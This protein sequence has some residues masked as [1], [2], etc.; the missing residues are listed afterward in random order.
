MALVAGLGVTAIPASAQDDGWIDVNFNDWHV[1]GGPSNWVVEA[2][3]GL[4]RQLTNGEFTT[5]VSDVDNLVDVEMRGQVRVDTGSDNDLIGLVA[6]HRRPVAA[7]DDPW[8]ETETVI[9]GWK[10]QA[11]GGAPEGMKLSSIN[12]TVITTTPNSFDNT[13]FSDPPRAGTTELDRDTG[14]GTGWRASTWY[15]V[16]MVYRHDLVE[17]YVDDVLRLSAEGTFLPGRIGVYDQSQAS[18]AYRDF[19]YRHLTSPPT[20]DAGDDVSFDLARSATLDGS[21]STDPDGDVLSYDWAIV[22]EVGGPFALSDAQTANPVVTAEGPGTATIELT[23]SDG[24]ATDTDTVEVTATGSLQPNADAG[25]DQEVDEGSTVTLDSTASRAGITTDLAPSDAGLS[26]PG[27]TSLQVDLAGLDPDETGLV[28]AGRAGIGEGPPVEATTLVYVLDVSGSTGGGGGCGGNPNGHGGSNTIL[29]CEI[30]AL[31]ALHADVLSAGTVDRVGLVSFSSG[32]S[33]VDLDPTGSVAYLVPPDADVDGDGILDV[34]EGARRLRDGGGTNTTSGVVRACDL[35]A[36]ADT[37]NLVTVLM[38]D[39]EATTG[40]SFA[41][42]LPCDPPVT[43]QS[44]G[45]GSANSCSSGPSGRTL[46]ELADLTGGTCTHVATVEDLPDVLPDAI[47]SRITAVSYTIDGGD[48]VDLSGELGLPVTGPGG[49][50]LSIALPPGLAAGTHELCVSVTGTDA[51]GADTVTTCSSLTTISGELTHTWTQVDASGPP[52][53]LAGANTATPSFVAPD[54]GTYTFEVAVTDGAGRS[55]TDRVRVTVSN[56][57]PT[58][59]V[60]S[61]RSVAGGVTVV[62]G[63]FLD[64]GW[65]DTHTASIDWGD[66]TSTAAQVAPQGSGWGAVF[67]SHV[68]ADAGTYTVEVALVDDDG[69]TVAASLTE[70][71]VSEPVALWANSE[72]AGNALDWSGGAG[73]VHGLVHSNDDVNI[74]GRLKTFDTVEY[75]GSLKVGG[76]TQMPAETAVVEASQHPLDHELA[77]FAPDGPV[78]AAV[79]DAWHDDSGSCAGGTWHVVNEVLEPGVH[80]VDCDVQLNGSALGGAVTLVATGTISIAG[81]R[82]VFEPYWDGLLFL[83]GSSADRAIE[84]NSQGS[85]MLGTIFAPDGE[86]SLASSDNRF[87]C[88]VV[89]DRVTITGS[90]LALTG[91]DCSTPDDTSVG[92]LFVP[93]VTVDVDGTTGELVPGQELS[94]SVTVSHDG[95]QLVVPGLVGFENVDEVTAT[96]AGFDLLVERQSVATGGWEPIASSADGTVDLTLEANARPGTTFGPDGPLGT[97]VEPGAWATWGAQAVVALDAP[98]VEDLLDPDV[99]S[100]LR[101]RVVFGLQPEG[102]QARRLYTYGTDLLPAIR[103][104]GGDVTA[105]VVTLLSPIDGPVLLD[106]DDE[107]ALASLAPG[108]VVTIERTWSAPAPAPRSV[109]EDDAGYLARLLALDGSTLA[110]AA[111]AT[112][113]GAVGQLVAPVDLSTATVHL[114]IVTVDTAGPDRLIAG[115]AGDWDVDLAEVGT[116]GA[117]DVDV[118]VDADGEVLTLDPSVP[119]TLAVGE[120]F[121]STATWTSPTSPQSADVR[122]AVTWT[123]AAGTTYG[124]LGSNAPVNVRAPGALAVSLADALTTD[125][126]GDGRV[127]PGDTLTY[128]MAV[129]NSGGTALDDVV[130]TVPV[131]TGAT[132]VTGS[133]SVGTFADG[134]LTVPVGTLAAG[135]STTITFAV[136]VDDPF[137]TGLTGL[138]TVAT[139]SAPGVEDAVSDDPD[140]PGSANATTTAVVVPTPVLVAYLAGE[141]AIDADTSMTLSGGDTIRYDLEVASL[142]SQAVTGAVATVPIPAGTTLVA[143]SATTDT[144]TVSTTTDAVVVDLGDLAPEAR[145]A[146]AFKVTVDVPEAVQQVSAQATVTA[147]NH[148]DVASDDP[149]TFDPFGDATVLFVHGAPGGGGGGGTGGGGTGGGNPEEPPATIEPLS[150]ADGTT[151]TMPLDFATTLSAPDGETVSWVVTARRAGDAAAIELAAGDGPDVAATLDPTRLANGSWVVE[152]TA[153][154]SAGAISMVQAHVA[155]DGDFKPGRFVT[156]YLDLDV[157][158]AGLPV[159]VRRTYDSFD[160]STGDFGVGWSLDVADFEVSTNGPLGQGGWT[161]QGCGTGLVFVP[162]CFT[163]DTPHVVTVTW[164]DG[165]VEQFDLTPAKGSTFFPGLTTAQFTARPGATSKLAA[166]NNSLYF[167]NGDLLSGLFGIDGIYNPRQFRLTDQFGTEYLLGTRTGLVSMRDRLGDTVTIDED[168]ITSTSGTSVAFV[169]DAQGRITTVDG[170]GDQDVTYRYDTAGDLVEVVDHAGVSTGYRYEDHRLVE[171]LGDDEARLG[172]LEYVDGR[173]TRVLDAEGNPTEIASDVDGRAETVTTATGR[174]V[175]TLYDEDGNVERLVETGDERTYETLFEYERGLVT[176]RT[177]P[178]GR[179]WEASYDDSGRPEWIKD[180]TGAVRTFEFHP[181][182]GLLAA[183]EGPNPGQRVEYTYDA[184]GNLERFT[185]ATDRWITYGYDAR[186]R[187]T[188]MTDADGTTAWTYDAEGNL[189]TATDANNHTTKFETDHAGRPTVIT[190]PREGITRIA[191]DA[192]GAITSVETPTGGLTEWIYDPYRR[193]ER[194]VGP[195]DGEV[196]FTRD[197]AGRVTRVVDPEDRVTEYG[198][199]RAGR[200][201]SVTALDPDGPDAV[202]TMDY[203]EMGWLKSVTDPTGVTTSYE[204]DAAGRTVAVVDGAGRR[205]TTEWDA[206]DR[207]T[208]SEAP[209]GAFQSWTYDD[210]GFLVGTADNVGSTTYVN[211]D[212]GRV[213]EFLDQLDHLTRYGYDDV[214]RLETITDHRDGVVTYDYDAVGDVTSITDPIGVERTFT[215][216]DVGDLETATLPGAGTTTWVRD[217]SGRVETSTD[218]R[219][220]EVTYGWDDADRLTSVDVAGEHHGYDYDTTG[221]LTGMVDP[222]GTTTYQRDTRG[223]LTGVTDAAGTVAYGYDLAGRRTSLT[224]PTAL[225]QVITHDDAGAPDTIDVE[226][227]GVVD[228]GFDGDGR[229]ASLERPNGVDSTWTYDAAG[230]LD[231]VGH[232]LADGTTRAWDVTRDVAGNV[233][234]LDGPDGTSSYELDDLNRLVAAT[235]PDGDYAWTYD[236]ASNRTSQTVD[237]VITGSDIDPDTGL[238]TSVGGEAVTHDA[239]GNVTSVGDDT[240]TWDWAGRLASS[241]TDEGTGTYDYAGDGLRVEVDGQPQLLDRTTGSLLAAGGD[242]FAHG[243]AGPLAQEVGGEAGW[244]QADHLGSI[245]GVTDPS[246]ALAGTATF[247]PFGVQAATGT[248]SPFGF[249]GHLQDP[250]G[251]V[252]APLRSMDPGMGR[253]L[254]Q[255][256]VQPGAP[257]SAGYNLY[258]YVG[259]NPTSWTDPT[260]GVALVE[261]ASLIGRSALVGGILGGAFGLGIGAFACDSPSDWT[262]LA[263]WGFGGL[264]GGALGGAAW[265]LAAALGL[266][267]WAAGL[268]GGGVGGFTDSATRQGVAGGGVDWGAALLEGLI[269]AAAGGIL[270]AIIPALARR[271]GVSRS[272]STPSTGTGAADDF[273]R[274]PLW[275]RNDFGAHR[276]YQRTDLI[277]P[278]FVD[279]LGRTNLQRMQDGLAPIGPDGRSVNLHHML[280]TQDGP[281]AEITATM[282]QQYSRILHINPNT[283]PSGIDRAAF[284]RWRSDYWQWRAKDFL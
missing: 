97:T 174:V 94:T 275:S 64:Q 228:V 72:T 267:M 186:G 266:P 125:V 131:P 203:Y 4:V 163:S 220:I 167:S 143:G 70:L 116:R 49:V 237:G 229:L 235:T 210:A 169:R 197:G 145:A 77:D 150:V 115:D 109:D 19:Q 187:R 120:R 3:G 281:I 55:D 118:D 108:D 122:A 147:T 216:D 61:G 172:T 80:W 261:Y 12:G 89:G 165:R 98:A 277:D 46:Q 153:T 232:A 99:T 246:G 254:S 15:D 193:V 106:A 241:A 214:G 58:I 16:R 130:V 221:L 207:V 110:T 205:F 154:T 119:T 236:A 20:A 222:V 43:F 164:P 247:D 162:L 273:A 26:L 90:E 134:I 92:P 280:Q 7:G 17:V 144:G 251:L 27:G 223:R 34:V 211:D 41:S 141:L 5:M 28:A 173:L 142:G 259:S 22:A 6:G 124:P 76:Q 272:T 256:P 82:P 279:D 188:S 201:T 50:D 52:I 47:A 249:T 81:S 88:A 202:S 103:A 53:F 240:Y 65:L 56:V 180:A 148:A 25:D 40:S 100:G 102:V 51:G 175:T 135:A 59:E 101:T 200:V 269:G 177:D 257:G 156:T 196:R 168:G 60:D 86:V 73:T 133:A 117:L 161:M 264:V 224:S 204:Y 66:G 1:E 278:S 209:S 199:D 74:V 212:A 185:D 129:T 231:T 191:Y 93:D 10:E 29:D 155:V 181:R 244:L 206:L 258:G 183:I 112:G 270:D 71:G 245:T 262:C 158:V 111:F 13:W 151:V 23:V 253:W 260:G 157:G 45:V 2:G 127:S 139:A 57:D 230:R 159:Q 239:A 250:T 126:G 37:P 171:V 284:N 87:H 67:G 14:G 48:P 218:A 8:Q 35:L 33:Q 194:I 38:S 271:L 152:V 227:L 84:L 234:A 107:P 132:A 265:A 213:V 140:R 83:S 243:P 113:T 75:V 217:A 176:K 54:D 123:D 268:I 138:T 170:P 179:T 18:V 24:T 11:Q 39:G 215:Y 274:S 219:G 69:G 276:V 255:D 63:S 9:F 252:A 190:D 160:R 283:I 36:T 96:V 226:G 21:G 263:S 282:H 242:A 166:V 68:Y 146:I 62:S 137:P 31:E 198:H 42:V 32:S 233:T 208:R 104:A 195:D 225:D 238:L 184:D 91:A 192:V 114:P 30:A 44:F 79:G 178:L 136:L 85:K 149:A 189:E 105:P 121:S 128:T 248:A 182:F 78:A 95:G